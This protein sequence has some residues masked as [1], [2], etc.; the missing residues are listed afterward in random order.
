M[1]EAFNNKLPVAVALLAIKKKPLDL[2][3]GTVTTV[4]VAKLGR[5]RTGAPYEPNRFRKGY[6]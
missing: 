4:G 6:E 2:S 3:K 5:W 1:R